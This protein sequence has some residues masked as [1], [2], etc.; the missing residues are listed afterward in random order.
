MWY[1]YNRGRDY[2]VG[3]T[4]HRRDKMNKIDIIHKIAEIDAKLSNN[5]FNRTLTEEQV[6]K[7]H[8]KRDNL[9]RK[10]YK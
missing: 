7:L 6:R 3:Y 10:L 8:N 4:D 1:N 5:R 9:E 2:T